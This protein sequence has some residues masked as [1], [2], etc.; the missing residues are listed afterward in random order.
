VHTLAVTV[1]FGIITAAP[2]A[3]GAVGFTLQYGVTNVLNLA[4][5][6]IT[7]SAV[8]VTSL[9]GRSSSTLAVLVIAGAIWGG[10]FSWILNRA[11]VAPYIRR[12]TNLL[13]MAILTIALGLIIEFGLESI[14]GP[15]VL[16][17]PLSQGSPLKIFSVVISTSQITVVALASF[18]MI[19]MHLILRHTR[20]GLAMRAMA[21]DPSLS[22]TSGISTG[23][24]RGITWAVSGAL[25]GV[26]G[27][28]LGTSIGTFDST[29]GNNL[30]IYIVA[31]A[32][33]GGIGRPY[34]AIVG[35]LVIG[36]VSEG[37]SVVISP[38]LNYV[39]A[40]AVIVGMLILR[41]QG[42]FQDYASM[43]ELTE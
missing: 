41:P 30:F 28:L 42:I 13:G 39:A 20:L 38:D 8:F 32:I 29:V 27:T 9:V 5:G 14:Q 25:C 33:V 19:L 31:A 35:A 17:Y 10:A 22:R 37:A 3:V 21:S 12:G 2:I 24:V 18:L 1:I 7:T 40:A 43:R 23:R 15:D 6:A 34:G 4:Y 36:I 26:A 16:T 11:V